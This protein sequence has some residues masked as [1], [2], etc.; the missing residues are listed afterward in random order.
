[1]R[2]VLDAAAQHIEH[3]ALADLALK[4]GEELLARRAGGREVEG[5]GDVGLRDEQEGRQLGEV[6]GVLAVVVARRTL[7]PAALGRARNDQALQAL[8]SRVGLHA[9]APHQV[10]IKYGCLWR[11]G[12]LQALLKS[13][14]LRGSNRRLLIK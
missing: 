5:F 10:P 7:A 9:S 13:L 12:H 14:P 4:P 11:I 3:A 6:N 1:M 2:P 8:L